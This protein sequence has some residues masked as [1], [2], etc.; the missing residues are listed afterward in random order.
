MVKFQATVEAPNRRVDAGKAK[1]TAKAK[2]LLPA[3]TAAI[4]QSNAAATAVG[5]SA[6]RP[7]NPRWGALA[8][9]CVGTKR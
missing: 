4:N 8:W 5:T 1:D 3:Q 7:S 6:G 2:E 9:G